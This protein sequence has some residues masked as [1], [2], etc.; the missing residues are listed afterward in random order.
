MQEELNRLAN[1]YREAGNAI[2]DAIRE[3]ISQAGGF[4]NTTNNR[5]EKKDMKALVFN[6]AKGYSETFPIRAM[7]IAE[8][9]SVEVYVGTYGTIYTDKF[10][11]SKRSDERWMSLKDSNILFFQTILSIANTIDL[12]LPKEG[13]VL[14]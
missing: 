8:N 4:L 2:H 13:E 12:Y 11:R 3:Q 10:L 14:D 6:S 5:Q 7:R 1:S 9:G